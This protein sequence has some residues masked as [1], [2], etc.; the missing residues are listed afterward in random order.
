[1]GEIWPRKYRNV[2]APKEVKRLW[3]QIDIG[4]NAI[5][6][7]RDRLK[8][9][10]GACGGGDKRKG[11]ARQRVGVQDKMGPAESSNR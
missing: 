6:A 3:R 4:G 1:M 10:K 11:I 9:E 8:E 2:K 5:D 7:E